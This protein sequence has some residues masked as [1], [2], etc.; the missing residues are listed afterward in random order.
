MSAID[1]SSGVCPPFLRLQWWHEQT[2]FSQ[3]EVPPRERGITWSRFSSVRGNLRPQYWQVLLS[4]AKM[5]KRE[6]H[7]ALGNALVRRQ[8]QYPRHPNKTAYS[9][10]PLVM[11]LK[12]QIAPRV[13]IEGPVLFVH[14]SRYSL[15]EQCK[16]AFY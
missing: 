11:Y 10:H 13:K 9:S 1:A 5:L 15:I 12:R 16:S 6:P 3:V 14:R 7:V 2:M 4:R 8:Q